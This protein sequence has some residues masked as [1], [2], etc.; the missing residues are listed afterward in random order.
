MNNDGNAQN[1]TYN[2]QQGSP[3]RRTRSHVP[4]AS[5]G[6]QNGE[7]DEGDIVPQDSISNAPSRNVTSVT[8]KANGSTRM[9]SE[10][11]TERTRM[12]AKHHIRTCPKSP[13]K[14]ATAGALDREES[15]G[16]QPPRVSSRAVVRIP[17][18][19]RK[20]KEVLRES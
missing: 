11:K 20:N 18:S 19:P 2:N 9:T 8:P 1:A 4:I 3:T 14:E 10:R 15:K 7:V 12:S 16:S 6:T 17:T 13:P 5:H